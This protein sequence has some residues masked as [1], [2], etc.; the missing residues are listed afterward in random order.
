MERNGPEIVD[1]NVASH[2]NDVAVPICLA[3]GFIEQRGYDAAVR[4]TRRPLELRSEM[5]MTEDAIVLINEE[6]EA[7]SRTVILPAAE[8]AVEHA[9]RQ[10]NFASRRALAHAFGGER[11]L[12]PL[13]YTRIQIWR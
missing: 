13:R 2:G 12:V 10:G 5:D 8:A 7:K 4:M 9:M 6:L 11:D 3:H 1:G